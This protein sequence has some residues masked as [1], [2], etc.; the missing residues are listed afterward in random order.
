RNNPLS[1]AGYDMFTPFLRDEIVSIDDYV[2]MDEPAFMYGM[3]L[4]KNHPDKILS[5]LARRLLTRE[6]FGYSDIDNE[7][8]IAEMKKKVEACGFDSEY[9][10]TVDRAKQQP[11]Q[12]YRGKE[13]SL[14]WVMLKD[15]RIRELSDV[16]V[17]VQAIVKGEDKSDRK[18]FFP[19]K[20]IEVIHE[21]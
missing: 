13:S 8:S 1:L 18:M 14:I 4:C 5:D 9:Y 10:L 2:A 20:C 21:K 11:Y 3:A 15:G 7:K 12:P 16:S 17:I 6:L 19:K